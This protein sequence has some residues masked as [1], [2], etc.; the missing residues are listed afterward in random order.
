MFSCEFC[1]ILKNTFFAEHFRVTA[2]G[3]FKVLA[4]KSS[5]T[6]YVACAKHGSIIN[7]D[8]S[9]IWL[10]FGSYKQFIDWPDGLITLISFFSHML[11]QKHEHADGIKLPYISVHRNLAT[12][13]KKSVFE[14]EAT[15]SK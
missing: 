10:I 13:F 15:I 5:G 7:A 11:A 8:F 14:F 6:S 2:S 12:M 9:V 3:S 4:S 1:E